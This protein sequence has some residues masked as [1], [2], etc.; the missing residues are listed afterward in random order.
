MS[1]P[2]QEPE[3]AQL[4]IRKGPDAELSVGGLRLA[5]GRREVGDIDG[6]VTLRVWGLDAGGRE[7]ELLRLDLFRER[8][9]YHAPADKQA[10]TRIDV[11]PGG[12]IAWAI[13]AL[14][15]RAPALAREAGYQAIGERLDAAA[16]AE[17]GPA[18]RSL[19]AGLDEP[20]EISTVEVPKSLLD[21]LATR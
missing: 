15:T 3:M 8:P 18:L 19:L 7:V 1:A 6:G 16:L 14:T 4:E 2:E 12:S 20:N 9:H 10:E 13:D 11:A 5:A 21:G 17:A